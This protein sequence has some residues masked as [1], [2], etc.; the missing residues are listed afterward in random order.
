[1]VLT[2]GLT[3]LIVV[4]GSDTKYG[5]SLLPLPILAH[6]L[7]IHRQR[8]KCMGDWDRSQI[9][10]QVPPSLPC[11]STSLVTRRKRFL[12]ARI[13]CMY[14]DVHTYGLHT[15]WCEQAPTH[16]RYG[17]CMGPYTNVLRA[18][19]A[20]VWRSPSPANML[21]RLQP[22]V[23]PP[24]RARNGWAV[25]PARLPTWARERS[26]GQAGRASPLACAQAPR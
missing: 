23:L 19:A 15:T 3:T 9:R 4:S 14:N 13:V 7:P 20:P 2:S 11:A 16:N 17:S 21:L 26:L 1:M 6:T 12:N 25:E 5:N 10:S 22:S 8:W 24:D 18:A